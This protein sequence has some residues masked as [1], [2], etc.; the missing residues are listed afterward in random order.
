MES[1]EEELRAGQLELL[2]AARARLEEGEGGRR[3]WHTAPRLARSRT[4]D[5]STLRASYCPIA[6]LGGG[7]PARM[8]RQGCVVKKVS[9]STCLYK[10][11]EA[12]RGYKGTA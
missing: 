10:V 2:P 7:A 12:A 11:R 3:R 9:T 5:L 6:W 4:L 1:V 8:G